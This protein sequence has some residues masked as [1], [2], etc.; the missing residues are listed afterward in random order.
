MDK[1]NKEVA[2]EDEGDK[3]EL[4]ELLVTIQRDPMVKIPT[5]IYEHELPIIQELYGEDHVE[6]LKRQL[7][8]VDYFDA[9]TEYDRLV[10]KYAMSQDKMIVRKVLGSNPRQLA[11]EAGLDYSPRSGKHK[12]TKL[13]ESAVVDNNDGRVVETLEDNTGVDT[14]AVEKAAERTENK[15]A[16]AAAPKASAKAALADAPAKT[17]LRLDVSPGPAKLPSAKAT[18]APAKATAK[19]GTKKAASKK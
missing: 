15:T 7:V 9:D 14:S 5:T 11:Q 18:K 12:A 2:T 10:R 6:V 4:V 19:A 17:P 8:R 1:T 13:A 16:R 3:I